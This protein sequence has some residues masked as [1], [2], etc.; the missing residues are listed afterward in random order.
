MSKFYKKA[1]ILTFG[2]IVIAIS[3]F[4]KPDLGVGNMIEIIL[5]WIVF[6]IGASE[7]DYEIHNLEERIKKLENK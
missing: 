3:Y 4:Y 5:L 2:I 6:L 1:L 7:M